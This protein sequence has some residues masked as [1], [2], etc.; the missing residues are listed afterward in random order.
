MGFVVISGRQVHPDR[1]LV[2]VAER[3]PPEQ[4][5]ADDM[6][7]DTAGEIGRPGQHGFLQGSARTD[8]PP[9]YAERS[10]AR[11]VLPLI[12]QSSDVEEDR[13]AL[14][15]QPDVEPELALRLGHGD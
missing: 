10:V 8:L 15:L 14:A 9:F 3:V 2:R 12:A 1:T 5:T 13:L 6:L 4:L 11:R 7:V